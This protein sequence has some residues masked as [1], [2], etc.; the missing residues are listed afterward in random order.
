MHT[1]L[2]PLLSLQ[3]S[4]YIYAFLLAKEKFC[5]DK[6]RKLLPALIV[7]YVDG[8]REGGGVQISS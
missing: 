7:K 6:N 3:F 2:P 4:L 8:A 1:Y 5:L